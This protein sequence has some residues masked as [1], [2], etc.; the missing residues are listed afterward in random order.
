VK[1]FCGIDPGLD[2]ALVFMDDELTIVHAALMP[3]LAEVK[4]L[5]GGKS[6]RVRLIDE[7]ALSQVL[8]RY[9]HE[10]K[11]VAVEALP[12]GHAS[13]RGVNSALTMGIHHGL[14]RG[15]L[16]GLRIPYTLVPPK[17][18][19]SAFIPGSG[20]TKLRSVERAQRMFPDLDLTPGKRSKPHDGLA[21][22]V[23]LACWARKEYDP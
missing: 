21:D 22:A 2:G 16:A 20:D 10:L 8:L 14:V 13:L 3:V 6:R 5:S 23:H 7:G 17:R 11:L 19:Q 15:V 18:W 9:E 1:L 4:K 12:R